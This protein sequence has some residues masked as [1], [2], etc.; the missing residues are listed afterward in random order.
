MAV[1]RADDRSALWNRTSLKLWQYFVIAVG[2]LAPMSLGLLLAYLLGSILPA[3]ESGMAL[4]DKMTWAWSVPFLAFMPL[5]PGVFEE[6][7]FRGYIQSRLAKRWSPWAAIVM[8]SLMFGVM[9]VV[10]HVIIF[11]FVLGLWLGY[12]AHRTN[13]VFPSIVCHATINF[14]WNLRRVG[15]KF[16]QWPEIPP[17]WFNVA[18]AAAILGCFLWSCWI[19]KSLPGSPT[20]ESNV[21][22]AD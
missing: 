16:F 13:S 6:L 15:I 11:A 4:Y 3:D 17:L 2:A 19:L 1:A 18:L 21:E 22:F 14:I 8:T 5:V 9:H 20:T 12:V 10:P 7:L